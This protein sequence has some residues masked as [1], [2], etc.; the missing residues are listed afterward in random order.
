MQQEQNMSEGT[1]R[2]PFTKGNYTFSKF[3]LYEH[4]TPVFK[5][6]QNGSY[7]RFGDNNDY[8]DYL[9]YLYNRSAIHAAIV[10][11]KVN[12]IFGKG[13]KVKD[14]G[15]IEMQ[16]KAAHI[17]NSVN[18][19][20]SLDELSMELLF[21]WKV[22]GGYY[23]SITKIAG[24]IISMKV[25]P[26]ATVRTNKEKSIYFLSN[27]WTSD[28]SL[29]NK[30][31]SV[32]DKL[33][34]DVKV[35][36]K[37]DPTVANGE[38]L[39]CYSDHR[40]SMLVYPLPEYE[41]AIAAIETEVE[42]RN[43][44]LNNI[45]SGFS[46]GTMLTMMQGMP[47]EE[48]KAMYERQLKG[49][50]SG[51]DNAGELIINWQNQ[52]TEEPKVINLRNEAIANQMEQIDPRIQ[53][54][55]LTGHLVT[56]GMLFGIK[57]TG[58]LGGRNELQTS[59]ELL[60]NTYVRPNQIE[61]EKT[62]NYLLKFYELPPMLELQQL[63]P[64]GLGIDMQDVKEALGTDKFAEFVKDKLGILDEV[65]ELS[66]DKIILNTLNSLSP[67]VANKLMN[68]ISVNEL[69]KLL[70]LPEIEG[71]DTSSELDT[72][73]PQ[74]F[75]IKKKKKGDYVLQRLIENL[76]EPMSN[77]DI[78]EDGAAF[79]F[80]EVIGLKDDNEKVYKALVDN[81]NI[82]LDKL[83]EVTKIEKGKLLQ[84]IERLQQ[85]NYIVANMKE[86]GGKVEIKTEVN[87]ESTEPEDGYTLETRW[88]YAWA[89]ES[90]KSTIDRSRDF[91][92][93]LLKADKAYTRAEIEQLQ[94]DM[95]EEQF[96]TSV[97]RYR[98]GW[99]HNP[100][101]GINTPYCRHFWK[102]FIVRRRV[103]S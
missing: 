56:S 4:K 75:N 62:I 69:R 77:F 22:Y 40:P 7:I 20:Q 91:C 71:G 60:Y 17:V 18:T 66:E 103:Q 41:A 92:V 78:I 52:G 83:S 89:N 46:A 39:F 73:T 63:E 49:K 79:N 86:V 95:D 80:N 24:R 43:Y 28:L 98:G 87:I 55:V 102:S 25:V 32:R 88:R 53:Q 27:E 37:F 45:K 2:E 94:N 13:W 68:S 29:D 85:G 96:N 6:N 48:N 21:D 57:E 12:Y 65:E 74:S 19:Y 3:P 84:I 58:Q 26:F 82:T 8:P 30:F 33:P 50:A 23:L 16:A 38:M 70:R 34:K 72:P 64:I 1:P 81:K 15:S 42:I 31:K 10:R 93:E 51:S 97:W 35:I 14:L 59:W 99:Y 44:D 90:D 101:T 61:L 11:G 9:T 5:E 67:I 54:A 47:S 36:K 76:G 100:N